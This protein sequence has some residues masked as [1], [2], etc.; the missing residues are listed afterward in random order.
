MHLD[1]KNFGP[2]AEGRLELRPLTILIG[3]NQSGKSFAAMATHAMLKSLATL[4]NRRIWGAY[5]AFRERFRDRLFL[6]HRPHV[7]ETLRELHHRSINLNANQVLRFEPKTVSALESLTQAGMLRDAMKASFEEVFA[8]K[9]PELVHYRQKA[10][11]INMVSDDWRLGLDLATSDSHVSFGLASLSNLG[12][13]Y[14]DR[15]RKDTPQSATMTLIQYKPSEQARHQDYQTYAMDLATS[16]RRLVKLPDLPTTTEPF[17]LPA[18]RSGLLLS[19]RLF[20]SLLLKNVQRMG[21]EQFSIPQMTGVT[22]DF[23]QALLRVQDYP[24]DLI[25]GSRTINAFETDIT[26]GEVYSRQ[27]S[28]ETLPAYRFRTSD[29]L[30]IPLNLASS[31]VTEVAPIF[32]LLRRMTSQH[33]WV[34]I[35]EPES[36][37]SPTN[38]AI[39][40]KFIAALV[41]MGTRIIITTHSTFLL[42]QLNNLISAY[43]ADPKSHNAINPSQVSAHHLV[44]Q[45]RSKGSLLEQL[46]I[47][48]TDGIDLS[49][50]IL[51]Y[52]ALYEEGMLLK[53]QAELK[54]VKPTV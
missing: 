44:V 4:D 21:L 42:E 31:T 5:P 3:P 17:Y 39:M 28:G 10:G 20:L 45:D 7:S 47:D 32:L 38:Q 16:V 25:K 36:H 46:T 27:D 11:S 6:A 49:D 35:E 8:S 18:I 12:L 15:R 9:L 19:H 24:P 41:K 14:M 52:E 22:A 53:G 33:G 30:D 48:P 2:I 40:A 29:G 26:G 54:K 23:L 1:F 34:I 37:L 50:F 13:V 51:A 43:A